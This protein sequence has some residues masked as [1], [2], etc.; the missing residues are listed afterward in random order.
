MLHDS[1]APQVILKTTLIVAATELP[2]D[3][4]PRMAT[5]VSPT[6]TVIDKDL[7]KIQAKKNPAWAG[8]PE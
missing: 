3:I 8:F 5:L 6:N 7:K 2:S 4:S 1:D